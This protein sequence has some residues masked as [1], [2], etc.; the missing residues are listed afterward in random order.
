MGSDRS[1]VTRIFGR[2]VYVIVK[3]VRLSRWV[4]RW[5][6]LAAWR[7]SSSSWEGLADT[8]WCDEL[9]SPLITECLAGAEGS[10]CTDGN[11]TRIC[12]CMAFLGVRKGFEVRSSIFWRS[13]KS[14]VLGWVM[15]NGSQESC[16]EEESTGRKR[17]K[18][19]RPA[20]SSSN[21]R[22]CHFPLGECR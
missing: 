2:D 3:R 5:E 18:Q 14:I 12:N 13:S 16:R 9:G 7:W 4:S 19:S 17:S 11:V 10:R 1:L 21:T 8:N 6:G 15:H 20:D 22:K